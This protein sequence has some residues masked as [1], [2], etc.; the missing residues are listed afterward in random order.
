MKINLLENPQEEAR[1]PRK[2]PFV[3][4]SAMVLAIVVPF[5]FIQTTFLPNLNPFL[6]IGS[7]LENFQ[8]QHITEWVSQLGKLIRSDDKTLK[9]ETEDRINFLLLGMGGAGHEG[10]YLTDTIILVSI[11]PKE[12]Q[13]AMVSIPRDTLVQ[14]PGYGSRK[15]N[16]IN[17]FAE[18]KEKGSGGEETAKVLSE[19]LQIPIQYY[20][21]I[22]FAGFET[23]VDKLGGLS[24]YVDQSFTDY[25]YP[26]DDYKYQVV[27][28]EEGWQIMNGATALEYVRSR[29]GTNG[30]ASDFARSKRQQKILVA[31]KD[32]ILSLGT[33]LNPFKLQSVYEA[34]QSAIST[35]LEM[36]EILKLRDLSKDIDSSKI[37]RQVIDDS[38]GGLLV[39][40]NVDGAY[41]L[42]PR[43]GN[44]GD[45]QSLVKNIFE[46]S[47][48]PAEEQK[49]EPTRLEI[50]NGTKKPG[51]AGRASQMFT[52][53]G[54]KVVKIG[55]AKEQNYERTIIYDL[56]GGKKDDELNFLKQKLDADLALSVSSLLTSSATPTEVALQNPTG[57]N[58]SGSN[59][60]FL[61]IL[62]QNANF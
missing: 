8:F 45:I 34:S 25:Q 7:V 49:P 58:P 6:K 3:W 5:F 50:Q 54:Y 30:E 57:G 1:P 51:L 27:S 31:L 19:V 61:I 62:G 59:A 35:N 41:V 21:R 52:E 26:T 23:L 9:G 46:V 48:P 38:P 32:K 44:F 4:K 56:T 15:V 53:L 12:K 24:I 10:P 43:S 39:A 11:K 18:V 42:L 55:N 28:F 22:D 14:I 20:V 16:N 40:S 60:D 37:I 36:W 13:V 2:F 47:A 17:A 33:F 29:H